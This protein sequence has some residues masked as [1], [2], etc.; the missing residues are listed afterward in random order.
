MV[1][2][3]LQIKRDIYIS[4]GDT[5]AQRGEEWDDQVRLEYQDYYVVRGTLQKGE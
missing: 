4:G 5:K 3:G 1:S 2:K